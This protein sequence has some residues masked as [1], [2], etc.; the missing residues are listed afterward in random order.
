MWLE[1]FH[2]VDSFFLC[3]RTKHTTMELQDVG[4][5]A[6]KLI[7]TNLTMV[8]SQQMPMIKRMQHTTPT[9]A[10]NC[11]CKSCYVFHC[12]MQN[13][14]IVTVKSNFCQDSI[15]RLMANPRIQNAWC[16]HPQG[17]KLVDEIEWKN[18]T[19]EDS[20]CK[21]LSE[22]ERNLK[23][24]WVARRERE[25]ESTGAQG[26]KFKFTSDSYSVFINSLK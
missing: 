5:N 7:Q 23:L 17:K 21:L 11:N 9:S 15:A 19:P 8:L 16:I 6:I 1:V 25:R 22:Y 4:C 20:N 18:W 10:H 3:M 24:L 12:R 13:I 2:S 14:G 26:R